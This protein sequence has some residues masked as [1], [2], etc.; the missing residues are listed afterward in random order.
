MRKRQT[1]MN[2]SRQA[3]RHRYTYRER[4]EREERYDQGHISMHL[5]MS[6]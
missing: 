2:T 6:P 4:R 3:D 1:H 5:L